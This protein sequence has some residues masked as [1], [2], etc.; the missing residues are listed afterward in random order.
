MNNIK[1]NLIVFSFMISFVI[2]GVFSIQAKGEEVNNS[3][4][5]IEGEWKNQNGE[6]VSLKDLSGKPV[7]MT[8]GYTGCAHACPMIISKVKEI[9]KELKNKK[10]ESYR[11]VFLSFD[12][13]K[14]RPKDL[15]KYLTKKDLDE[16]I[17]TM[18]SADK[19]SVV[20]QLANSL[21]INYKDVGDGDF[22]HSNVI[23]VLD[24][25]GVVLSKI[26]NLNSSVE[27]LVKALGEINGK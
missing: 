20:R 11:V 21:E 15:K 27:S 12:T 19:D 25:K 10:V 7:I 26:E 14:D 1:L 3:L 16:K 17:W 18:L 8:M 9:E 24:A 13:I 5:Q 2:N 6:S 23:A 4:Y 22:A